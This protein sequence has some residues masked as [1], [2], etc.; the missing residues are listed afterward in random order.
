MAVDRH[1]GFL[2]IEILLQMSKCVI[3]PNLVAIGPYAD[4]I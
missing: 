2:K 4:E 1:L 3:M